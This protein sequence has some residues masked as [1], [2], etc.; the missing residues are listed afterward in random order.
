MTDFPSN[1]KCIRVKCASARQECA[2]EDAG[3]EFVVGNAVLVAVLGN[4]LPCVEGA[5]KAGLGRAAV[6]IS[7]CWVVREMLLDKETFLTGDRGRE[8]FRGLS[9][10]SQRRQWQTGAG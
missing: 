8:A 5:G 4:H 6:I 10:R 9:P 7:A 2:R 3:G 1:A